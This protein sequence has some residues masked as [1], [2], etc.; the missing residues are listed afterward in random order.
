MTGNVH[1]E[2]GFRLLPGTSAASL[3]R[4][5]LVALVGGGAVALVSFGAMVI[6]DS[7]GSPLPSGFF[8]VPL[9]AVGVSLVGRVLGF[10]AGRRA[11]REAEAGYTTIAGR[12]NLPHRDPRTGAVLPAE[13]LP[14]PATVQLNAVSVEA[15]VLGGPPVSSATSH[16]PVARFRRRIPLVVTLLGALLFLGIA[17]GLPLM[18]GEGS[19]S[20]LGSGLPIVL[21]I[22]TPIALMLAL[23]LIYHGVSAA[24]EARKISTML[25]NAVVFCS[26]ATVDG[27]DALILLGATGTPP[28]NR[29]TVAMRPDGLELLRMGEVDSFAKVPWS[30]VVSVEP[31][32]AYI[33]G[34]TGAR[35]IIV[36]VRVG[37]SVHTL[38]LPV[39][40]PRMPWMLPIG[41][42]NRRL[43]QMRLLWGES[44]RAARNQSAASG[45]SV[46][47]TEAAR[48]S[49]GS[50]VATTEP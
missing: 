43:D 5:A 21:R 50:S 40:D 39:L 22:G 2:G 42:A 29:F 20:D 25:R 35:A 11:D 36:G 26:T 47:S 37:D 27:G 30:A 14:N 23:F 15:S 41:A 7:I 31:G 32:T 33:R 28:R 3:N 8:A 19:L 45:G 1:P 24:S 9:V 38:P 46:S 34:G 13:P 44:Q 49:Q 6:S 4:V 10:A 48:P 18:V 12:P 16:S 17:I